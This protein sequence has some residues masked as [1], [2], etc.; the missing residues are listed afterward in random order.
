MNMPWDQPEKLQP[1]KIRL[2]L[3]ERVELHE[4]QVLV[5]LLL[6]L[7]DWLL[8]AL[9]RIQDEVSD[10]QRVCVELSDL[11]RAMGEIADIEW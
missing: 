8:Q 6:S 9:E 7:L 5:L 3:G 4:D 11:N 1:L 2:I 10:N